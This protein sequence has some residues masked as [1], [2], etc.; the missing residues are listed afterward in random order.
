M[1]VLDAAMIARAHWGRLD[2]RDR[3]ELAR[4]VKKSHGLPNNLTSR[5]RSELGRL[6]R[7]LDPVTAGRKLLPF[8][9]LVP[10]SKR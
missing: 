1:L 5:E 2:D 7:L 8:H 4:I 9:G 6:V 10:R 3:H